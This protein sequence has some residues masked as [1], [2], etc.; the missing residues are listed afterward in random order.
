MSRS[1]ASAT[2]AP[3]SDG[4]ETFTIYG[5]FARS[6]TPVTTVQYSLDDDDFL[7]E[8]SYAGIHLGV[9]PGSPALRQGAGPITGGF[10]DDPVQVSRSSPADAMNYVALECL[11]RAYGYNTQIVEVFDQAAVDLYGVRKDTSIKARAICDPALCGQVVA[12]LVLQRNLA[13]RNTYTFRLGWNYCLLEPM[14]LVAISDTYLGLENQVVRI[15]SVAEDEEGTLTF[16]AEDWF[17]AVGAPGTPPQ[18][19]AK[20]G[21]APT[22][23]TPELPEPGAGGRGTLHP[24][25]DAAAPAGAGHRPAADHHRAGG[26]G[27]DL[28]RRPGLRLDRQRELPPPQGT[29]IGRSTMGV[30][31]ADLPASGTSLTVDLSASGGALVSNS[32][33]A[34]ANGVSLCALRYPGRPARIPQLHDRDPR[35]G[36]RLHPDR[37]LSRALRHAD[38]RSAGRRAVPLSRL[39][40]ILRADPA[41]AIC[42]PQPLAQGPELQPHRRRRPEPRRGAEPTS[43]RRR[44]RS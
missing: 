26:T 11:D 34:A 2:S 3:G 40:P 39:G 10:V 36:Q 35:L 44:A 1:R 29:F 28:R 30:S 12:Q 13:Y 41:A 27:A 23:S 21:F 5:P 16:T 25:A 37:P 20:Q 6:W 18:M 31:T 43:T 38:L 8:A 42:R 24:R 33:L 14:D 22:A 32:P 17:G 15:T 7:A 19:A 9:T 4:A